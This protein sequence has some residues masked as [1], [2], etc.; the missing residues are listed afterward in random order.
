[1]YVC[2]V[3]FSSNKTINWLTI[4]KSST[5]IQLLSNSVLTRLISYLFFSENENV[6]HVILNSRL[7]FML[8]TV[9][10]IY[11]V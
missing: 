6:I 8:D 3:Q 4:Y 5:N 10:T 9:V 2:M 1:V 7:F 11:V